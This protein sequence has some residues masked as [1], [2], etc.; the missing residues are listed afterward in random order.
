MDILKFENSSYSVNMRKLAR[1][2]RLGFG[3]QDIK[4]ITIQD[5]LIMN[6]H[7][8]L[9]KIYYGLDKITF[10]DDILEELGIAED[11]RIEKP[12]KIR[13]Y[14]KRD[15]MVKKAMV[16]VKS[17]KKEEVAA[18]REMAKEMRAEIKAELE[19]DKKKK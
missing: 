6:K 1:K 8:E 13:D 10:M 2:S 12:G 19:E 5:I 18:F 15:V 11:M 7:K 3:Y 16:T 9:I 14:P 4:H 17:R